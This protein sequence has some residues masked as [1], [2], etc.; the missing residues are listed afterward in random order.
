MLSELLHLFRER[1]RN[2]LVVHGFPPRRSWLMGVYFA[3]LFVVPVL[4]CA[5]LYETHRHRAPSFGELEA[6]L[7]VTG[8][9]T[10]LLVP[11]SIFL[12]S[13][14]FRRPGRTE[15]LYLTR[16]SPNEVL[17]GS[18]YWGVIGALIPV[19]I[20][21][22]WHIAMA[23]HRPYIASV[24]GWLIDRGWQ[25]FPINPS[26]LLLY[27]LG[28]FAA[29]AKSLQLWIRG[30]GAMRTAAI[31]LVLVTA[32]ATVFVFAVIVQS[33]L[34][35]Q[36]MIPRRP[37]SFL[38]WGV[39]TVLPL[40]SIA[41]AA[42]IAR[43]GAAYFRAVDP[44]IYIRCDWL[45]RERET[46]S[47]TKAA[48]RAARRRLGAALRPHLPMLLGYAFLG[49]TAA[50]FLYAI[51][52][53]SYE[54]FYLAA[55]MPFFLSLGSLGAAL[56]VGLRLQDPRLRLP[57]LSGLLVESTVRGFVPMAV[58]GTATFFF[59]VALETGS[60]MS[61]LFTGE[62]AIV[63]WLYFVGQSLYAYLAWLLVMPRRGRA[64]MCWTLALLVAAGWVA[65]LAVW[66]SESFVLFSRIV[67]LIVAVVMTALPLGLMGLLLQRLHESE[68]LDH[69]LLML[70]TEPAPRPAGEHAGR[71]SAEPPGVGV[72]A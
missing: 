43:A 68:I 30:E 71:A 15:E 23:V 34:R 67:M 35:F 39:L 17:F 45:A 5:W 57:V 36:L 47:Q 31:P 24:P 49:Q 20:F 3:A 62:E 4:L 70:S 1:R 8:L 52:L 37:L 58:A 13:W 54:Q 42:T 6:M 46:W 38:V 48:R 33:P 51:I 26:F 60:L 12:L 10:A 69:P 16:L 41:V 7:W 2:P 14:N 61:A 44:E 27:A 72:P 56:A 40:I 28:A 65:A 64:A 50:L 59:L 53:K 18:L 29:L 9:A 21:L 11:V 25:T 19:G 55:D 22:A 32:V 66:D 63:Y